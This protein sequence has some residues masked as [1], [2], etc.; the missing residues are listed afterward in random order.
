MENVTAGIVNFRYIFEPYGE[1]APKS[2]L[3]N[4]I[5][6]DVGNASADGVFDHH[7]S[8][9]LN[10]AFEAVII[11]ADHFTGLRKYLATYRGNFPEVIF[12]VHEYPDT[13]CV[14]SVYAIQKMIRDNATDPKSALKEKV[15]DALL[16]YVNEIDSGRKKVISTLTLYAYFCKIGTRGADVATRSRE[17]LEEGLRLMEMVSEAIEKSEKEIDLFRTPIQEYLDTS[18]L[19]YYE[20]AIADIERCRRSYQNDKQENRVKL[21]RVMLWN[22]EKKSPELVKAA[23]WETRASEED[24]YIFA[25]DDDQCLLTVYYP[26]IEKDEQT[27]SETTRVIISLNPNIPE[28]YSFT[29]RPLAEILEQF[30]QIEEER[31]YR[32]TGRYR[33]DHSK[34]RDTSGIFASAPFSETSD[35]W[36]ISRKE[37]MIDAPRMR[38]I[39]PYE[40]ILSIIRNCTSEEGSSGDSNADQIKL[41]RL[42]WS[43]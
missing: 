28:A 25:R 27:E 15:A 1:I 6:V 21:E 18:K 13:D 24:Q 43:D 10:S 17:I 35:P 26:E 40:R 38:S 41:L 23:I 19:R 3:T 29:L 2:I 34:A 37:D 39:L 14:L 20:T 7:Q 32:E 16:E 5:W 30:E 12:H 33:R 22:T 31:L 9:E 11:H 36:Y 42:N 4:E 8:W